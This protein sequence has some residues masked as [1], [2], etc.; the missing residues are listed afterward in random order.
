M[1]SWHPTDGRIATA[2]GGGAF[3]LAL[4]G[5]RHHEVLDLVRKVVTESAVSI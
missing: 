2:R 4:V 5:V 1:I 3:D